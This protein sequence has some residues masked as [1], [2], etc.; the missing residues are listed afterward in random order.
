MNKLI[1]KDFYSDLI[2]IKT[3][4]PENLS[5]INFKLTLEVGYSDDDVGINYFYI[6]VATPD[7][8]KARSEFL[9]VE[10]RTL[11]VSNFDYKKLLNC[12]NAI[13]KKSS[14]A[15]YEESCAVLQR[16]F[17]WEYEDYAEE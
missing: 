17:N 10:N 2:D 3:W 8:L 4:E 12:L 5:E 6:N 9:L 16:Y 15:T 1:L 14:R 11:V 7:A 13:L